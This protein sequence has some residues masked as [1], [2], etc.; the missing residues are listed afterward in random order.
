MVATATEQAVS[1]PVT[2]SVVE[3]R[4][5]S[6]TYR[7]MMGKELHAVSDLSLT[8][9]RGETFAIVGPNGSGK[10]TT[11]KILL[12][13]LFPTS[14]EVSLFGKPA[15]DASVQARVGYLPEAPYFY[16]FLNGRELLHLYG[17]LCDVPEDVLA[18][19][20]EALLKMVDLHE[21]GADLPIRAYSR[22]MRQ[23]IGIAQ[24]MINE[25]EL[26]ILDEPTNGLDPIG[27]VQVRQFILEQ[28]RQGRT[29]LLCSHLLSEV[30]AVADRVA[31]LH[32]GQ[33]IAAGP[34]SEL[35][36]ESQVWQLVATELSREAIGALKEA[37]LAPD[38]H[39]DVVIIRAH[40]LDDIY[41]AL[42]QVRDQ[43]GQLVEITRPQS[44]L[45]EQFLKAVGEEDL[46]RTV[47]T[48][49]KS[50]GKKKK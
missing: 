6:K 19:R 31:I 1:P 23:R 29:M 50:T 9:E 27:T 42:G 2:A 37:G 14:G 3:I 8:I 41:A 49:K 15:G 47:D 48:L 12:G 36:P 43:G 24:A 10:T 25:P 11:M 33:L 32:R 21:R 13:L 5:L 34:V 44:T 7:L 46:R 22:G 20:A 38:V 40:S 30:E 17:K 28:K 39:G 45:E 35:V 18:Q 26:L 16:E 4:N